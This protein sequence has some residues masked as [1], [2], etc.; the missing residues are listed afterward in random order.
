MVPLT[1]DYLVCD[2]IE[3]M[4]E[5]EIWLVI[6]CRLGS[7]NHA[8]L[9]LAKLEAMARRPTHIMINAADISENI[10]L[11]ATKHA[12]TPFLAK[13]SRVHTL[14]RGEMIHFPLD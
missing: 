9:T 8:L 5:A 10:S 11:D 1:D 14:R 6:G 2:W 12:I 7:I 13:E 4:P 3:D